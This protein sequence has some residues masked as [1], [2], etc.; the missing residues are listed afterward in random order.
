MPGVEHLQALENLAPATIIDVGANKGQFS[1]AA[2]YLF[3][4]AKIVAFEPLVD[5]F[6]R[7]R[8][9]VTAPVETF[10]CALGDAELTSRFFVTSRADSSST[11]TPVRAENQPFDLTVSRVINV[12]Q[13]RGAAV[14]DLAA[15][16]KPILLKLDIQGGELA[17]LKG[18]APY[19]SA[20]SAIYC[21]V[22]YISV[23]EGQ[24]LAGTIVDYLWD[25]GFCVCGVFNQTATSSGVP[26]Q[27]DFLFKPRVD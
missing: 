9:V 4:A 15:L 19:L 6:A 13:C 3:P 11:L 1:A 10:D 23:Y 8:K 22:S 5:E 18:F 7:F 12:K 2:R 21:E 27:A 26:V 25:Q 20:V 17:A 16:P 24:P 14:L